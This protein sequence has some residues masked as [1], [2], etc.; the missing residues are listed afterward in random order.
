MKLQLHSLALAASLLASI[1]QAAPS[2]YPTGVTRYDPQKAWNGY[3]LFGAADEKTY[4]I[5][6]NGNEIR[7]WEH[8]G[9]PS[10]LIDPAVNG[11]QRGHVLVRLEKRKELDPRGFGNG[12]NTHAIGELDWNGKLVWKWGEQAPGGSALQHHDWQRLANGNTLLLANKLH[13]IEGFKLDETIDDVIYEVDPDGRIV[14]QWL[15][16]E[17]LE[18]FGFTA[19]QLELV[20]NTDKADYLH[21]NDL[22]TLGPNKWYEQ[23]DQRFHPDNLIVDSREA[24]F[25]AI[26]DK[27]TGKVVWNLGPNYPALAPVNASLPR[28]VDQLAGLHDANLIPRGYPGEGNILIFDN[29]GGSGYPALPASI[30]GG[31]RVVE[32]DPLSKQIVWQYNATNS[33]QPI[34]QFNSTFIS[35]ARRLP[36]GNTLIDEGM[37]GRIFQ[38]TPA[39][40]I[41]WEYVS[42]YFGKF[43]YG[44]ATSNWLYRAQ[45]VPYDWVPAG[46]PRSEKAVTPPALSDFRVPTNH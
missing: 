46:T 28:P 38:V 11:G 13:R 9:S 42:P 20:R 18:E 24:N 39:G 26:I 10:G 27:R 43:P 19:E 5:D 33:A 44:N 40:E 22:K 35:S 7:R 12:L 6:A 14:W 29:Q 3:V 41:V 30:I 16:S 32:I 37:F 21:F 36:N 8:V 25:V 2:V 1:A 4:L 31:S 45:P 23:G 34:W 15:A 17:H